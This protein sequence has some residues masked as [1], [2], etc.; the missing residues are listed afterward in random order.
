[1]SYLVDIHEVATGRTA[2]WTAEWNWKDDDQYLW[3][4]GNFGCDCNRSRFFYRA[5]GIDDMEEPDCTE[6][7]Y[8][9]RCYRSEIT[10][11]GIVVPC[12]EYYRDEAFP[13]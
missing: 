6:G 13:N 7:K 12:A 10:T 11:N 4:E 5:I 9:V 3:T 1:M 8:F 2:T